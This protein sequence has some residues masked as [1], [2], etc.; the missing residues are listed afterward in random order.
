VRRVLFLTL[1]VACRGQGKQERIP[2]GND[3][4][5]VPEHKELGTVPYT[6]TEAIAMDVADDKLAGPETVVHDVDQ[7][8]YFVSNIK[9]DPNAQDD[10]GYIAKISPSGEVLDQF[11]IDGREPNI[12][13]HSPKGMAIGGDTLFVADEDGVRLFDRKTG[14]PKGFWPVPGA[15]FLN[16]VAIDAKGRVLV[17]E[18]GIDL[19]PT[20]PVKTGP[21]IV[22]AFDGNGHASVLAQGDQLL[23]PNGI[24]AGPQGIYT[25]EFMGDE[26]GVYKLDD[27][28][29][30]QLLGQL[31]FGEL[32]G[33]AMLPD[34]SMLVT[35][36]FA[37]G[38]YRFVPGQAPKLV[39]QHMATPAGIA[40][41]AVRHRIL[42]P[43][44]VANTLHIEPWAPPAANLLPIEDR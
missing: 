21:Y 9:G 40:Y 8:V 32:D 30:K 25:I 11:F 28:G 12:E 29:Q 7:D 33:L 2:H 16:S 22:Y 18:T 37:N 17:T 6:G 35:S 13:L 42:I 31:P 27:N 38:V 39:V 1:L 14:E 44:V 23:G 20:G 34:G 43:E 5:S 15:R 36:W 19:L 24:V 4:S 3:V 41:D 26:H 10:N